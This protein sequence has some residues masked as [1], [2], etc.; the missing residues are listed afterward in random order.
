MQKTATPR[1]A[2]ETCVTNEINQFQVH[3][4]DSVLDMIIF[5]FQK[6]VDNTCRPIA[7]L[8]SANDMNEPRNND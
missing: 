1:A 3:I 7:I 6:R 2:N 4:L 8:S 5:Y